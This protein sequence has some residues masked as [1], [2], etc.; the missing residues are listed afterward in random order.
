VKP[1]CTRSK[2]LLT[3]WKQSSANLKLLKGISTRYCSI[4]ET[5]SSKRRSISLKTE[6]RST[7]RW[8]GQLFL[9]TDFSRQ[10]R[11]SKMWSKSN[12]SQRKRFRTSAGGCSRRSRGWR[13]REN[14]KQVYW[15]TTSSRW[16]FTSRRARLCKAR[17]RSEAVKTTTCSAVSKPSTIW[18][19][20]KAWRMHPPSRMPTALTWELETPLRRKGMM[21]EWEGQ[22]KAT[23]STSTSKQRS[24]I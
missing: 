11:R 7:A 2:W 10:S 21:E 18:R 24:R 4:S 9:R 22:R 20:R 13:R 8:P 14:G 3:R 17:S 1:R 19:W 12:A 23:Q 15:R 16:V 6:A 5:W